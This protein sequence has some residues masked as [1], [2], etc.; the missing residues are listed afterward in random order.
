[1][2]V[3]AELTLIDP[4]ARSARQH[5]GS[6]QQCRQQ[7]DARRRQRAPGRRALGAAFVRECAQVLHRVGAR[8]AR[9]CAAR[10]WGCSWSRT[11]SGTLP[12]SYAGSRCTCV[13]PAA[14]SSSRCAQPAP[15]QAARLSGRPA[16]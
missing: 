9:A 1:M 12:K 10:A 15:P 11:R 14:A 8:R 2:G 6:Q 3:D 7:A 13:S 4:H 16:C 5:A